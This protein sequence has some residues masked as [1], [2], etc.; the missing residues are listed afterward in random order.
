MGV[1]NLIL[2]NFRAGL[3]LEGKVNCPF[4]LEAVRILLLFDQ[5]DGF[6]GSI[7]ILASRWQLFM[8]A[9]GL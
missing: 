8:F 4:I 2:S 3:V 5:S 7:N 9:E 1:F 6:L